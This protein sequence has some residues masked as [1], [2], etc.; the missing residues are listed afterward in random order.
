MHHVCFPRIFNVSRPID[1]GA[2]GGKSREDEIIA[3][4]RQQRGD[5]CCCCCCCCRFSCCRRC[6]SEGVRFHDGRRLL[7]LTLGGLNRTAVL[8]EYDVFFLFDIF[9][10]RGNFFDC[11]RFVV[12]RFFFLVVTYIN[13]FFLVSYSIFLSFLRTAFSVYLVSCDDWVQSVG[14]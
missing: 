11:V 1:R 10:R 2:E 3:S 6:C 4:R 14:P 13:I 9:R 7:R 12:L 5:C 8:N